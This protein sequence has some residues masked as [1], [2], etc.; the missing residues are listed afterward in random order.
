MQGVTA[1]A[2]DLWFLAHLHHWIL[3]ETPLGYPADT[4]SLGDAVDIVSQDQS[5]PRSNRS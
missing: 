5:L 3:T 4:L 1:L 2:L